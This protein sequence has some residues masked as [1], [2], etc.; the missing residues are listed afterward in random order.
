M[1]WSSR[2]PLLRDSVE[3]LCLGFSYTVV[4]AVHL[5]NADSKHLLVI[6]SLDESIDTHPHTDL[7]ISITL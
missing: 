4:L 1:R 7:L 3:T 6:L 5:L 2:D